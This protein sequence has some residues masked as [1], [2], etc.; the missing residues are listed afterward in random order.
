MDMF[1]LYNSLRISAIATFIA[2]LTGVGAAYAVFKMPKVLKGIFD[3]IL[4]I[5][6]VLPPTVVGYFILVWFS[7]KSFIGGKLLEY[8]DIVITMRWYASVIVVSIIAFPFIY[9]TVRGAFESLDNNIVNAGRTLGMSDFSVFVLVMLPNC[10]QGILAGTALAFARGLGEYG[11]TS[12]VSGYIA[13]KTA[14][15][16]TSVAYFWQINQQDKV[17]YW[18]LINLIISFIFMILL[19]IFN[20]EKRNR[21]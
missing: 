5:P 16:S 17:M 8:F 21:T 11:A 10:K 9:R 4:T 20:K 12:M 3:T 14:T 7:P 6:M 2:L 18:V 13:G 19:N 1:P 15:V